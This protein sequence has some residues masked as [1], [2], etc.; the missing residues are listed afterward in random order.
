MF[1]LFNDEES[2]NRGIQTF[3]FTNEDIVRSEI[4]R[5]LVKKLESHNIHV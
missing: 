4:L 1:N 5:F 3:A 2:K